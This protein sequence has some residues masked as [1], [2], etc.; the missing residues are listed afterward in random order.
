MCGTS[1]WCTRGRLGPT[2]WMRTSRYRLRATGIE[3][4]SGVFAEEHVSCDLEQCK[5]Q[6]QTRRFSRQ[7][8]WM[9]F[10]GWVSSTFQAI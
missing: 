9:V 1:G 2:C 6:Q 4:T 8:P 5:C 7:N 10:N 3:V